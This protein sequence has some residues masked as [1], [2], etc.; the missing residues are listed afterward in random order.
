MSSCKQIE[1]FKGYPLDTQ[2]DGQIDEHTQTDGQMDE[3]TQMDRWTNTQ[4]DEHDDSS[5]PPNFVTGEIYITYQ[6]KQY[7]LQTTYKQYI[8][9]NHT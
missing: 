6:I 8:T 2:T 9:S 4:T 7:L 3:H 1:H 5:I